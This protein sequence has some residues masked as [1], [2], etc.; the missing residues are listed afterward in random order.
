MKLKSSAIALAVAGALGASMVAQADSGFYGSIRVGVVYTDG[1]AT[2]EPAGINHTGA[3]APEHTDV[4]ATTTSEK[5][6]D[7]KSVSSRF[8][9]RGETDMG[10]GLTGFGRFEWA[11]SNTG[12]VSGRHMYAG[13]KGDWG[14]L[15][16][17]QTYHTFY[18]YVLAGLDN[19]WRGTGFTTTWTGY[20]GR[21]PSAATYN[22]EFG[23]VN[24][25][26]TIYM[27]N[28]TEGSDGSPN[29]LDAYEL[30][31][32]GQAGPVTLAF[33]YSDVDETD[34]D[35]AYGIVAKNWNIGIFTLGAGYFAQ[36]NGAAPGTASSIIFDMYIGNAYVHLETKDNDSG[37]TVGEKPMLATLGYTQSV[38]R[39]T[40]AYYEIYNLDTDGELNAANTSADELSVAA[41]LKYDWK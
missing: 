23:A 36:G 19:P 35:A 24:I 7:I 6:T 40:T 32:S 13:L 17:G 1:P 16:A 4:D 14:S 30:G 10:N 33:A 5:S 28:S 29:D 8:G 27:D 2:D 26:A 3:N 9:F 34:S 21:L 12:A 18:N 15:L 22:G 37:A 25:G 41:V 31:I 38:G 39:Q 20:R 11:V